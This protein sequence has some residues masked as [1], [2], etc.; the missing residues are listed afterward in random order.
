MKILMN[1]KDKKSLWRFVNKRGMADDWQGIMQRCQT[2]RHIVSHELH[3][4]WIKYESIFRETNK[5]HREL[6]PVGL[7]S[8]EKADW[9][10]RNDLCRLEFINE[11]I[12]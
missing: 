6:R 10:H 7:D 3:N 4:N 5:F 8:L 2:S 12:G 9:K 11:K 1:L